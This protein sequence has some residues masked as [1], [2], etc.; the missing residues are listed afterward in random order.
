QGQLETARA[1]LAGRGVGGDAATAAFATAISKVVAASPGALGREGG[2]SRVLSRLKSSSEGHAFT[3]QVRAAARAMAKLATAVM[4]TLR[5]GSEVDYA[6][7]KAEVAAEAQ[8]L[9]DLADGHGRELAALSRRVEAAV[10]Q[11]EAWQQ[12]KAE[13]PEFAAEEA[14]REEAWS[15]ANREANSRALRE[16]RALIPQAAGVSADGGGGATRVG[17][18]S[19]EGV[20]YP[21]DL[22]VRLKECRP[23]HWL[24]SAPEDIA[25]ANF[26]AGEGAAAFTQL[27]GMDLTEM[28]AV[29]SVLPRE[30]LRDGDGKKAEWRA[31]FRV[32]L[33]G[34]AR[35][36]DGAVVTAGW[37]P[38]RRR[39]AT[40][41]MPP[42]PA[43]R[44]RHPA[45]FYPSAEAMASRVA[46]LR[47]QRRR[48]D[49]RKRRLSELEVELG[50]AKA[51]VDSACADA[52]SGELRERYGADT[53]RGAR[54][55]AK[56]AHSV[57][58]REKRC[59]LASVAEAEKMLSSTYPSLTQLEA[60]AESIAG[61]LDRAATAAAA[62]NNGITPPKDGEIAA[63]IPDSTSASAPTDRP[64]VAA[65]AA[66][67]VV[68]V[69]GAFSAEPEL[70]RRAVAA[71]RKLTPE[72]ERRLRAG[73]VQ[74]AVSSRDVV[75]GVGGGQ[76][77]ITGPAVAVAELSSATG[78]G[79]VAGTGA[80]KSAEARPKGKGSAAPAPFAVAASAAGS[81][82]QSAETSSAGAGAVVP[83]ALSA[84]PMS[85]TLAALLARR[86]DRPTPS[87][88]AAGGG[89]DGDDNEARKK[90]TSPPLGFLG[91]L[92]ARAAAAGPEREGK[93]ALPTGGSFLD[94]LKART[95]R[96]S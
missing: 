10:G 91:E 62:G 32:Q 19:G 53:L 61:I 82:C 33:E 18:D 72:E 20:F 49:A 8:R 35:Q 68:R 23:L 12:R 89:C 80:G 47:E 15:E 88:P 14:A 94:E 40:T 57:L 56:E 2:S 9:R 96:I 4:A 78:S 31:R 25:G 38:V 73:E 27:E 24:V 46:R 75:G 29:W 41:R 81:E 1:R 54:E 60:E 64:S 66:V 17:G 30:F 13:A 86:A 44:A 58:V 7:V 71:A 51:E 93:A 83:V 65:T 39:R 37:D 87:G 22:C 43:H 92:K 28:R 3:D 6:S 16:M 26:L 67:G 79:G 5:T 63:T 21:S 48:L 42:L 95:A 59:L 76:A 69:P 55:A 84:K 85:K 45:Y 52:R 74:R 11:M 90:A 34:L 77:T 50:E 36:Q 70:R